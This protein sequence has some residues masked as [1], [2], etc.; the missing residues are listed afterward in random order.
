M[1]HEPKPFVA[2]S[3]HERPNERPSFK[4]GAFRKCDLELFAKTQ[5]T[6]SPQTETQRANIRHKIKS[7][8][9]KPQAPPP[10]LFSFHRSQTKAYPRG[11][12]QES[13]PA[14]KLYH[15]C[16]GCID[17][18]KTAH[19]LLRADKKAQKTT[20]KERTMMILEQAFDIFDTSC[21]VCVCVNDHSSFILP[22]YIQ[23]HTIL[24][25]A[26]IARYLYQ[27]CV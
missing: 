11:D 23:R 6:L 18:L 26:I 17:H 8:V 12:R 10:R 9:C 21:G 3:I 2:V 7:W 15:C 13:P 4:E 5:V 14:R 25:M 19:F 22:W 1:N 24:V 20:R 27:K 16:I